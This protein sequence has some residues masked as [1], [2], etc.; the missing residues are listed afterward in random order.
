MAVIPDPVASAAT[1]TLRA[2]TGDGGF[3]LQD[4]TPVILSW[5][6]PDDGRLH[7]I[8]QVAYIHAASDMTGGNIGCSFTD[9][10]GN[11]V[12]D[13]V[14]VTGALSADF[15]NW[16][17]NVLLVQPGSVST[18]DQATALAAG[19]ATCWAEIWAT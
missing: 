2:I 19:A 1:L 15:S 17:S 9:P 12:T 6:A 3:A 4:G 7:S 14:F 8:M 13:P 5:T 16:N 11:S 10:D 18:V